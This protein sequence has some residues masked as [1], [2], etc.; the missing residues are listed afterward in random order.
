MQFG[1]IKLGGRLGGFTIINQPA[2]KLPQ[3][4]ATAIPTLC[5]GYVPLWYMG[6]QLVNG[7]NHAVVC[8]RN[9]ESEIVMVI[10]NIPPNSIGGKGAS[11]VSIL[12]SADLF[13]NLKDLFDEALN[14]L[15]GVTYKPIAFLGEQLVKGM[16]YFILTEAKVVYPDA[17]PY[18]AI[19]EI[20]VFQNKA[21]LLGIE[22]LGGLGYSFTW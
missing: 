17:K 20:N 19:V 9:N 11:I 13:G 1:N 6:T 18:P 2:D 4:L 16:N 7:V 10:I 14:G 3:D 22:R 12:D 15:V 5:P 21:T 8:S